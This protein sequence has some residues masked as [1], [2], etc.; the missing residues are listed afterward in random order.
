M[1]SAR[2]KS[3]SSGKEKFFDRFRSE[4][5]MEDHLLKPPFLNRHLA[6]HCTR[7]NSQTSSKWKRNQQNNPEAKKIIHV[8][9]NEMKWKCPGPKIL[10]LK[11]P[12][13]DLYFYGHMWPL[14]IFQK[15]KKGGG[16]FEKYAW[17]KVFGMETLYS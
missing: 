11:A 17:Q 8:G 13:V 7:K 12:E 10:L 2:R 16:D 3:P 1:T 4:N 14:E 6:S 9:H 15:K 5:R